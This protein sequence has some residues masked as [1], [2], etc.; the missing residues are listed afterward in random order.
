MVKEV[1]L[2]GE[3]TKGGNHIV[4][5]FSECPR[6]SQAYVAVCFPRTTFPW[7]QVLDSPIRTTEVNENHNDNMDILQNLTQANISES[8]AKH[9]CKPPS[10]A[11]V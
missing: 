10:L 1:I 4:S 9:A 3:R 2:Q 7:K 8:Q 11:G 5:D 6:S